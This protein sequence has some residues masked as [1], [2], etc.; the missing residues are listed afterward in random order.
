QSMLRQQLHP[1]PGA[2]RNS[3]LPR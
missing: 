1:G 2:W 3:T